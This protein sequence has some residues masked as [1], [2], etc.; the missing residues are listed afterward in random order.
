[1]LLGHES[2]PRLFGVV[3]G[4]TVSELVV[5]SKGQYLPS[6]IDVNDWNGKEGICLGLISDGR[7]FCF[8]TNR[9]ITCL[10]LMAA[11]VCGG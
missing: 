1:M 6:V 3:S 11:Y 4:N 10:M 5:H 7:K 2:H 8:Q 9:A